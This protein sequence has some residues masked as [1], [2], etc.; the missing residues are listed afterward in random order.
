YTARNFRKAFLIGQQLGRAVE[1]LVL[2]AIDLPPTRLE[3]RTEPF[4]MRMTNI[5]FRKR[6]VVDAA[7]GRPGLGLMPRALYTCPGGLPAAR[8]ACTD[9]GGGTELDPVVGE[10]RRGTHVESTVTLLEIADVSLLFLPG[11]VPGELV[12]G[13]PADVKA[14]PERWQDE[15]PEH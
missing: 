4:L 3:I 7:T 2:D 11:E 10:I 12:A 15:S 8:G 9:D 5:G 6:G 1:T 13:L 14:H